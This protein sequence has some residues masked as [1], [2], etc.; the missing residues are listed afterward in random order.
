MVSMSKGSRDNFAVH[1]ASPSD[2]WVVGDAGVVSHW[3]GSAWKPSTSR[4]D[5]ALFGV[6]AREDLVVAVGESQSILEYR[7]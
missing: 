2:V 3:N 7:R 4:V 1:G 5:V 6:W